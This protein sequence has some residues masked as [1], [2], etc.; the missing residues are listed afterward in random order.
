MYRLGVDIGLKADDP[1][2]IKPIEVINQSLAM[3]KF[4]SIQDHEKTWMIIMNQPELMDRAEY[5]GL[6]FDQS[7]T[8]YRGILDSAYNQITRANSDLDEAA[9][10]ALDSVSKSSL[11]FPIPTKILSDI[12]QNYHLLVEN[13]A[14]IVCDMNKAVAEVEGTLKQSDLLITYRIE[15]GRSLIYSPAMIDGGSSITLDLRRK[16]Y[17]NSILKDFFF[18]RGNNFYKE[19]QCK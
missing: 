9:R 16:Q 8:E 19:S 12:D 14:K 1:D 5:R 10:Y 17:M 7:E 13:A 2:A 4:A 18:R 6:I 3:A 15:N 11:I